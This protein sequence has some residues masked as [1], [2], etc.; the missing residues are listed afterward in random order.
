MDEKDISGILKQV[1]QGTPLREGIDDIIDGGLG[2]LIVVG[3]D[4]KIKKMI[5]GGFRLN[6]KFTPERLY[7]LSKMDGAIIVSEDCEEIKYANVHLQVERKFSS[8]ESGTRH[9]TAQRAGKETGK[10][11]IAISG[12]KNMVSLY[13]GE[14]KYKLKNLMAVMEEANQAIRTLERY[15]TVLDDELDNLTIFELDDLATFNEVC[16][17]LQRFEMLRRIEKEFLSSITEL[18]NEGRLISMQHKELMHGIREEEFDFLRDYSQQINYLRDEYS[19]YDSK[20]YAEYEEMIIDEIHEYLDGLSQGNIFSKE[21]FLVALGYPRNKA[22][23]TEVRTKGYRVLGKISKI[24][25][26]RDKLI[27]TYQNL[28]KLQETSEEELSTS[29]SRLKIRGLKKGIE[30]LKSTIKLKR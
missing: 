29:L 15:K 18:G 14:Q 16:I 19:D 6:C 9:R 23:D 12:R 20:E 24:F 5:D 11:V 27:S 21:E 30:K 2:A 3:Y 1:A 26:D 4:D 8:E 25:K 10:L 17:V 7:E 28:S 13:K 22:L